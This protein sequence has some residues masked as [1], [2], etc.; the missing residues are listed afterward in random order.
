LNLSNHSATTIPNARQTI[1][2]MQETIDAAKLPKGMIITVAAMTIPMIAW[3]E[4]E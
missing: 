4:T 1:L 3:K 2:M